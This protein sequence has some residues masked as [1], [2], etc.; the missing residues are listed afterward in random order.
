MRVLSDGDNRAAGGTGGDGGG[1]PPGDIP[2]EG[3]PD[4]PIGPTEDGIDDVQAPQEDAGAGD[5]LAS[6]GPVAA[7]L[8][9]GGG[10]LP[11]TGLEVWIL[12]V[13]GAWA[14]ASGYSLRR[15]LGR[16]TERMSL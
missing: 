9:A 2:D 3:P 6:P 5:T 12:L 10:A 16:D 11:F 1:P 4:R 15:G 7:A 14:L 8:S 13:I